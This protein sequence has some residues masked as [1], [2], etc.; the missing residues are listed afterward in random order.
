M[1][2]EWTDI[3][4]NKL[5]NKDKMQKSYYIKHN[6][7]SGFLV[8]SKNKLLFIE[9][10]G[11]LRKKYTLALEIPYNKIGNITVENST[12]LSISEDG[13]KHSF[14]S[15]DVPSSEIVENLEELIKMIT[16]IS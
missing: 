1:S 11:F 8:L 10:K 16:I 9:E 2:A 6:G 7:I 14:T 5:E 12:R 4:K 15:I 13:K 3:V